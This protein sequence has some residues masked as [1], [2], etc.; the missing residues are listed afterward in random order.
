MGSLTPAQAR[1]R[2][3]ALGAT[4]FIQ[5]S[6]AR[7]VTANVGTGIFHMPHTGHAGGLDLDCR[8]SEPKKCDH[9]GENE[10]WLFWASEVCYVYSSITR[11]SSLSLQAP[12]ITG[13]GTLSKIS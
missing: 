4:A 11:N 3:A 2:L 8:A 10:I 12:G 5:A 13:R 7:R 1:Q 6:K 9:H